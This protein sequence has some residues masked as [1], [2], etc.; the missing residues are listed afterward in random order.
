MD[1][2]DL[3]NGKVAL[4]DLVRKFRNDGPKNFFPFFPGP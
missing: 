3:Y 1:A 4:I 2:H